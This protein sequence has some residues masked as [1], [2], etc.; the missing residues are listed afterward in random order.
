[1]DFNETINQGVFDV[2]LGLMASGYDIANSDRISTIRNA[3]IAESWSPQVLRYFELARINDGRVNPY[4]PRASILASVS[5]LVERLSGEAHLAAIRAYLTSMDNLSPGDVDK[6]I[7]R[8]AADLPKHTAAIQSFRTYAKAWECYQQLIQNEISDNGNRYQEEM[9]AMQAR[10]RIMLPPLSSS[11]KLIS[12]LNPLQADSLTD[13]VRVQDQVYVVTSHLRSES[14]IH[15]LIHIL[16]A[17]WLHR[18]KEQISASTNLLDLVYDRMV[19]LT[20]AWDHSAASWG[21]VF[22]ET[23]VRVLTALVSS[24]DSEEQLSKITDLLDQGFVYAL[25]IA[26]TIAT[27]S[28]EQSLSEQWLERCLWN[29]AQLAK[30]EQE[31]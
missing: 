3:L 27:M 18:W 4:W 29:C 17:P 7:I 2:Y 10:L 22:S 14:C 5:L 19:H 28:V 12:I 11:P 13:I 26:E 1:M 21:N 20:Y 15:E 23:L 16:L 30:Q 6:R 25:P 9:L 8:W 31:T 24:D